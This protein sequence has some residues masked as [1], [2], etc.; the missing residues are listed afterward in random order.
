MSVC[1]IL[2]A[3]LQ[4]GIRVSHVLGLEMEGIIVTLVF[5]YRLNGLVNLF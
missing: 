1:D 3:V 4:G 2:G 5:Y